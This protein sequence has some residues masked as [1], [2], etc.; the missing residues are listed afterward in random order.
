M[1][2][3]ILY[4]FLMVLMATFSMRAYATY[5]CPQSG[6]LCVVVNGVTCCVNCSGGYS[7]EQTCNDGTMFMGCGASAP[8][9][10]CNSDGGD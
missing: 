9:G 5:E 8:S 4:L 1:K 2:K 10:I 6:T 3:S 7:W